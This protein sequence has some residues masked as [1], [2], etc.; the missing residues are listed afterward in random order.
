MFV[1]SCRFIGNTAFWVQKSTYFLVGLFP[2]NK[3]FLFL[4][5]VVRGHL[6]KRISSSSKS[7]VGLFSAIKVFRHSAKARIMS[8]ISKSSTLILIFLIDTLLHHD[9]LRTAADVIHQPD[10]LHHILG[11]E[12]LGHALTLGILFDQPGELFLAVLVYAVQIFI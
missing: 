1:P 4:Y 10:P 8:R 11:L 12:L 5:S 9:L 6:Q 7:S 2:E 3:C